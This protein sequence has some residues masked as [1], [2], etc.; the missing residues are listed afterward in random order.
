MHLLRK[1]PCPVWLMKGEPSASYRTI[2]AAVDFD[3][4]QAFAGR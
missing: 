1:C 2:L 3:P 4:L